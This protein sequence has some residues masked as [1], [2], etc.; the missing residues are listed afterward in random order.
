MSEEIRITRRGI[1][2]DSKEDRA[3]T[4]QFVEVELKEA[5]ATFRSQFTLL[6][7][8][9]AALLA[10]NVAYLGYALQLEKAAIIA[11]GA[12]FPLAVLV[13][14]FRAKKLMSPILFSAVNLEELIFD[15]GIGLVSNFLVHIHGQS[16]VDQLLS[17]SNEKDIEK[18]RRILK[19]LPI[20]MSS[21]GLVR[22][23]CVLAAVGQI[24]LS[25]V[26][27]LYFK[28]PLV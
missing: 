14:F 6:V 12:V 28:W 21:R 2:I 13:V 20:P 5:L 7:Q 17:L 26:L 16:Y 3:V 11:I 8:V 1:I 19:K 25:L 22:T 18:R 15:P 24:A 9:L 27:W 23:A 10:A 4:R